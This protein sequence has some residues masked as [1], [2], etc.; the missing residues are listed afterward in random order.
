MF[1][2]CR[3]LAKCRTSYQVQR[4]AGDMV[5]LLAADRYVLQLSIEQSCDGINNFSRILNCL[6]RFGKDLY[7]E[8]NEGEVRG[9]NGPAACHRSIERWCHS[10]RWRCGRS[11]RRRLPTSTSR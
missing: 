2:G 11:M 1:P 6:D 5:D 10:R 7:F 3:A 8:F 9:I 4:C